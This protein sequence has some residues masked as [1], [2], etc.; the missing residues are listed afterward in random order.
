MSVYL[1]GNQGMDSGAEGGMGGGVMWKNNQDSTGLS[2]MRHKY[3]Q[4]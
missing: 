2:T 3:G 4:V 1:K